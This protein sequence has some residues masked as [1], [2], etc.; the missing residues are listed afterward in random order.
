MTK[1]IS[2]ALAACALASTPAFAQTSAE[3]PLYPFYKPRDTRIDTAPFYYVNVA[4]GSASSPPSSV[5]VDTGSTGLYILQSSLTQGTYNLSSTPF[6][7][8]YSSGNQI[9]GY[10]GTANVYF[11]QSTGGVGGA[12]V[13]TPQPIAFGVITS[14]G[15]SDINPHCP[16]YRSISSTTNPN[17]FGWNINQ[18]G[19][20]G[21]AYAGGQ[22]IFNPLAQLTANYANGFLFQANRATGVSD[23]VLVVGLTTEMKAGYTFASFGENTKNGANEHLNA[24][25]TKS[26]YTCFTASGSTG[27]LRSIFDSGAG[28]ASFETEA[29]GGAMSK[30]KGEVL[31]PVSIGVDGVM[32]FTSNLG[33]YTYDPAHGNPSGYNTGNEIFLY[34]TVAYDY[35]A[36]AI[37]FKP[38]GNFLIGRTAFANDSD[39]GLPGAGVILIGTVTLGPNFVSSR[40]FNLAQ[41]SYLNLNSPTIAVNGSATLN[42]TLSS[43]ATGEVIFQG[44]PATQSTLTLNGV[45]L[46]SNTLSVNVQNLNLVVNGVLPGAV[47][48]TQGASLGGTGMIVGSVDAAAGTGIAPGNSIGTLTVLGNVTLQRNAT[49]TAEIGGAGSS[50]LLSVSGKAQLGGAN[51]TILPYAGMTPTVG[52]YTI[53]SA[54]GGVSG[55]FGALSAPAFGTP[56]SAYPFLTPSLAYTPTSVLLELSRSA[57]PYGSVAQTANHQQTASAID[58]TAPTNAVNVALS[59]LNAASAPAAF[60]AL[61]GEI[62]ASLQTGLQQQSVY[63]RDAAMTRVRQSFAQSGE[64]A[65]A[66]MKSVELTPGS[67]ATLWGQAYGG[68]GNTSATGNAASLSS[69]I[70]GFMMGIDAPVGQSGRVG[71]LGGFSQSTFSVGGRSSN[72]NSDNYDIALYG[73]MRMGDLGLRFGAGYTWH[74]LSVSRGVSAGTLLETETSGVAAGTSQVFGELGYS[75]HF[76][77]TAVEPFANAAYVNLSTNGLTETGGAAALTLGASSFETTYSVLGVRLS[78]ALATPQGPLLLSASAGWQHAFGDV[79]P[80]ASAAFYGSPSFTVTGVPLAT[81]AAVLDLGVSFN[82][83]ANMDVGLHYVGQ[84]ASSSQ[85]GAVKGIFSVRF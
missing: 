46:F 21:V 36:G 5:L 30:T 53:L 6:T 34:Y 49:Y 70:G 64:T 52:N 82:P 58:R 85:I 76:G 55:T 11:P 32:S 1:R 12:P 33:V 78:H 8:S 13:S 42:G 26:I 69:S 73:G 63:V 2:I 29:T 68:W 59:A 15:C 7:Y 51:V 22:T 50:D 23:P 72:A 17:N 35:M 57:V 19:V 45:N 14:I 3:I 10:V 20:M 84:L 65:A 18:S 74:D 66:G 39:I 9:S 4:I 67:V 41:S 38:V 79:L 81:D 83:S 54:T 48:L 44:V 25:N 60:D 77:A 71:L 31:G 40:P 80:T 28:N 27:C 37:G 16:G 61:S 62:Y 24:W 75:F 56:G 47:S 43:A